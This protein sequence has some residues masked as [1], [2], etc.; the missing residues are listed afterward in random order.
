MIALFIS[1]IF[2]NFFLLLFVLAISATILRVRRHRRNR[3]PVNVA[4]VLWGE[5]LF[6]SVGIGF[7][8]TGILHAYFQHIVAP[9]IGWQ[10]SPFEYEL[11]WM[12]IP[13]ALIAIMAVWRG[14]E[15]RLAATIVVA[16]F[17]LAAAAQHINEIMCCHN[18]APDNAGLLLWFGDIFVPLLLLTVAAL[19]VRTNGSR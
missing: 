2:E 1:G 3:E 7:A 5:L 15:F 13:I 10:P 16:V 9:S 17:L 18:Y 14:F 8:Y 6:Y 11:G 12:E 4:Y 19:S